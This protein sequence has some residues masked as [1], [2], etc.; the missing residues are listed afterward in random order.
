MKYEQT[1]TRDILTGI[2][3]VKKRSRATGFDYRGERER[4]TK[5][6]KNREVMKGRQGGS[7][8]H[9]VA[10]PPQWELGDTGDPLGKHHPIIARD[11]T[12]TPDAA[13]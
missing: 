6:N 4:G 11:N 1:L 9:T 10:V 13:T 3:V 8:S 7:R 12:P 5:T 2:S